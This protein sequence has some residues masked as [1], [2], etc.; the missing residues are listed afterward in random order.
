MGGDRPEYDY[1]K[2]CKD[3]LENMEG[4]MLLIPD[5]FREELPMENKEG[6]AMDKFL[7]HLMKLDATPDP[8]WDLVRKEL[9]IKI[10]PKDMEVPDL[11]KEFNIKPAK[12]DSVLVMSDNNGWCKAFMDAVPKGRVGKTKWEERWPFDYTEEDVMILMKGKWD[13]VV[14][15]C[16]LDPPASDES[17]DVVEHNENISKLYFWVLKA[18]FELK[19]K[20]PKRM[21]IITRGCM[22]HEEEV[23]KKAGLGI[24]AAGTLWGM[25][26]TA[27]LEFMTNEVPCILHYMDTEYDLLI[28]SQH[29]DKLPL[30]LAERVASEMFRMASFG[31]NTV[32][33]LNSGRYVY[34]FCFHKWFDVAPLDF[35]CPKDGYVLITGGNGALGLLMV[36]W[37][38]GKAK[39]QE[40][41]GFTV[42]C[43]S[44]S[45]KVSDEKM[46]KQIMKESKELN[47]EVVQDKVD[48]SSQEAVDDFIS[49]FDGQITGLIHS[50]G[51]LRDSTLGNLTWESFE[52]LYEAKHFPA[53]YLHSALEKFDQPDLKFYWIFS[54]VSAYG[55]PGQTNYSG[56]NSYLDSLARHRHALGKKTQAFQWA[57]WGEI[58]MA[59]NM[60]KVL[61]RRA[62][63]SIMPMFSNKE[64]LGGM[65]AGIRC[66]CPINAVLKVNAQ[67]GIEQQKADNHVALQ[68]TRNFYSEIMP[69]PIA[70][71]LKRDNLMTMYR[72]SR[73]LYQ[74]QKAEGWLLWYD[75]TFPRCEEDYGAGAYEM[76]L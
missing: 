10:N 32:R 6:D 8:Q 64:G 60:D 74:W 59:A 45:A 12:A 16:G 7:E 71:G 51:V 70:Q 68:Y 29:Q 26:N 56:S 57:G 9:N 47:I 39:E 63:Q 54:S 75:K 43:L 61:K 62:D 27:R 3:S 44:R 55:N 2:F 36:I 30:T 15:G 31:H 24:I 49:G 22:A 5:W 25:T 72:T 65:E 67:V 14:F 41:T 46:W 73:G 53:T 20:G 4:N 23:H 34:R 13:L 21:A 1:D 42:K 48:L 58:G 35:E 69:T 11:A 52:E 37:L 33:L 76:F 38:L 50:A 18:I 28:H 40:C 19:D 66:G 17:D